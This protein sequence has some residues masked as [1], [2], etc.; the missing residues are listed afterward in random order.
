M[1]KKLASWFF[2]VIFVLVAVA[3]I[4]WEFFYDPYRPTAYIGYTAPYEQEEG[5][6]RRDIDFPSYVLEVDLLAGEVVDRIELSENVPHIKTIAV[7]PKRG[8][9]YAGG[10]MLARHPERGHMPSKGIDVYDLNTKQKVKEINFPSS[11]TGEFR[12]VRVNTMRFNPGHKYLFINNP[13]KKESRETKLEQKP[14]W[15]ID[16]KKGEILDGYSSHYSTLDVL[17]P[18]GDYVYGFT[19]K[20]LG[21]SRWV[22]SVKE[23]TRVEYITGTDTLVEAGGWQPDPAGKYEEEPFTLDYPEMWGSK[24]VPF[25]DR[26]TLK[27]IGELDLEIKNKKIW[28]STPPRQQDA[29]NKTGRYT[30]TQVWMRDEGSNDPLIPYLMVIDMKEMKLVNTIQLGESGEIRGMTYVDVY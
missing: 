6:G 15:I 24:Q 19:S 13:L 17:S 8:L 11:K 29:V 7:D 21:P 25:Y 10:K 26:A 20:N 5:S 23:D 27:K 28:R 4:W 22:Y 12:E 18:S 9:L 14:V 2:G 16:P 3:F 30:A 1:I